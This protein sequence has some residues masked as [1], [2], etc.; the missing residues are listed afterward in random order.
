MFQNNP[1]GSI[2]RLVVTQKGKTHWTPV[3]DGQDKLDRDKPEQIANWVAATCTPGLSQNQTKEEILAR[4]NFYKRVHQYQTAHETNALAT[5]RLR[6]QRAWMDRSL[7]LSEAELAWRRW[8]SQVR[9]SAYWTGLIKR[10]IFRIKKRVEEELEMTHDVT[11]RAR[12]ALKVSSVEINPRNVLERINQSFIDTLGGL[13][14]YERSA[15]FEASFE[16][17]S[18]REDAEYLGVRSVIRAMRTFGCTMNTAEIFEM[19]EEVSGV[20]SMVDDLSIDIDDFCRISEHLYN[21]VIVAGGK[22]KLVVFIQEAGDL[23]VMDRFGSAD[24]F[25]TVEVLG[26]SDEDRRK[27]ATRKRSLNPAWHQEVSIFDVHASDVVLVSMWD[28]EESGFG[29]TLIGEFTMPLRDV[30]E[31]GDKINNT[32]DAVERWFE[33]T[34]DNFKVIVGKYGGATKLR[35][36]IAYVRGSLTELKQKPMGPQNMEFSLINIKIKSAQHLPKMDKGDNGS[37]DP[38]CVISY[39]DHKIRTRTCVQDYRFTHTSAHT[40]TQTQTNTHTHTHTN[41]D[42]HTHTDFLTPPLP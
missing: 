32:T 36:R 6:F 14:E 22:D 15:R 20:E 19:V 41:T 23:P 34:D 18:S 33:L 26:R 7:E 35:A 30:V 42:T 4:T 12:R 25:V 13:D 8:F 10:T 11:L 24:P 16:D 38:Y 37:V 40:H 17:V 2:E 28:D 5:D 1:R 27:T 21:A 29:A 9:K 39:F 31:A 3:L